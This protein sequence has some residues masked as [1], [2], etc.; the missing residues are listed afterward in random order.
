MKDKKYHII[1]KVTNLINNKIYIGKHS[2]NDKNDSYLGGSDII[3]SEIRIFG[4]KNFK[5]EILH[6]VSSIEELNILERNIVNEDFI[7]RDDTYNKTIGG[8]SGGFYYSNS[9]NLN[10]L[11]DQYKKASEKLKMDPE[12]KNLFRNKVKIGLKKFREKM[13]RPPLGFSGMSHSVESK[14]KISSSKK[15]AFKRNKEIN[16]NYGVCW[17]YS[18]KVKKSLLIKKEGIN[19]YLNDGWTKGRK[20]IF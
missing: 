15:E 7:K 9:N 10:N 4:R 2:T 18:E 8:P 19:K 3:N 11:S 16:P 14:E 13:N 20:L 6:E 1:Y 17:V 12:F 5:K